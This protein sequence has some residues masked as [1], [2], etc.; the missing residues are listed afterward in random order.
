MGTEWP[1]PLHATIGSDGFDEE[2]VFSVLRNKRRRYALHYLKQREETVSVGELAEQI[3][4][5][6]TETPLGDV[7]PDDRKRVYISLL[8][9]HLP[10]LEEAGMVEF[11]HDTSTIHLTHAAAEVDIYVELVPEQD[12]QWSTYYLG[13]AAFC[14]T[15]LAAAWLDVF[16]LTELPPTAWFGFVV[17]LFLGSSIVHHIHQQRS[18]LGHAGAPPECLLGRQPTDHVRHDRNTRLRHR[19]RRTSECEP[20]MNGMSGTSVSRSHEAGLETPSVERDNLFELLGNCRRRYVIEYFREHQGSATLDTLACHVAARE[21]ETVV[22]QV[23]AAERKRVY[24]SLQQTHL[25]RMDEAGA[26]TF[27]KERGVITPADHLAEFSLHLDVVSE[28]DVPDSLVYLSLSVVSL[29]LLAAVVADAP[30]VSSLSPFWWA[31][32]VLALFSGV[33]GVRHVSR[34]GE[35]LLER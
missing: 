33:A 26:V 24:T 13:V 20:G 8:Q 27:D 1:V 18:R 30:V 32:A 17:V 4:A 15:V 34:S 28:S 29:L 14:G 22:E 16:P 21:N 31:S 35:T 10:T 3:A 19:H 2:I 6:E 7:T 5:W 11:D 25:P 12:I 9:S 23:T